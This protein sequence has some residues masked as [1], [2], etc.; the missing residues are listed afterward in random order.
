[1]K[2]NSSLIGALVVVLFVLITFPLAH[3]HPAS[4]NDMA[5]V[6]AIESLVERGTW[7]IDDASWVEETKDKI[8]L[9]GKFYSDKMPVFTVIG[10]GVYAGLRLVAPNVSLAPACA[11]CAYPWLVRLLVALP[12]A[13]ALAL[14]FDFARRQN[15]P[16]W[17]AGVG[18][19]TLGIGTMLFPF[20]TVLN[21]HVPA[22][23]AVWAS[24]YLLATRRADRRAIFCAGVLA[25][26]ALSF[27]VLAGVVAATVGGIAVLRLRRDLVFFA[28]GGVIPLAFTA[29][30]DYQ[31]AGTLLP[32]Y[33]VTNG[34]AYPGSA[35][36]ATFAGNGT[37]DDYAAYAFR[38]FLGGKG[39][40]AFNP[41]L[42]LA[43]AGAVRVALTRRHPLRLEAV[44]VALGFIFLCAYLATQT[45]NYGGQAYG[46]RWFIPAIPLVGAFIFFAPPLDGKHPW[47]WL[48]FA[49]LL[50]ISAISSWQGAQAPWQDH[51]PV[52]QM[53]RDVNKFPYLGFRWNL[54]LP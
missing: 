48:A 11:A 18:T 39:L 50:I 15:V 7:A 36:P 54:R 38:M 22:A 14:M 19:L 32:P 4:W 28:L 23:G 49:P 45:G 40:F 34:Y 52:L 30:F 44:S 53:T 27:D 12:A 5:R 46:E 9:D 29:L 33:T 1:M 3:A 35:F 42:L 21:H 13:L 16:V 41:L 51:L 47:L 25:A 20:S 10:A 8:L 43:F 6:A 17:I 31:I 37:P 26:L 2:W 24:F